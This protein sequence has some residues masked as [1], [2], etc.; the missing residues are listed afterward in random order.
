MAKGHFL[1]LLFRYLPL[2][3]LFHP[4]YYANLSHSQPSK[5]FLVF[6]CLFLSGHFLFSHSLSISLSQSQSLAYEL[7]LLPFLPPSEVIFII[8][9]LQSPS[10]PI[11]LHQL[12]WVFSHTLSHT[13]THSHTRS[14]TRAHKI[15]LTYTRSHIRDV[16]LIINWF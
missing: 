13:Y 8:L 15:F 14:H 2:P 1:I 4:L 7:Q 3:I 5:S 16:H 12:T 6:I 11:I 9:R 10:V